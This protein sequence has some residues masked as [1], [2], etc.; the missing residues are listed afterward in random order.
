M[1]TKIM[2][3]KLKK[4]KVLKDFEKQFDG[5]SVL[6]L[7]D[8]GRGKS[9]LMQAIEIALGSKKSI[10]TEFN[11]SEGVVEVDK[12]GM[13]YTFSFK[14][15]KKGEL[16]LSVILPN[17]IKEDKKG[18]IAGIVGAIDFDINEFV[19][20]SD[21]TAGRKKQV[22]M[23]KK[24]LPA[25]I[26]A[27]LDAMNKKVQMSY[28]D[29]TELNRKI[30]TLKGFLNE[31]N[32][33]GKD[34]KVQPVDVSALTLELEKANA[35]NK[36]IEEVESR[37][38]E[39]ERSISSGQQRKKHIEEQ[40]AALMQEAE[41]VDKTIQE[42]SAKNVQATEWLKTNQKVDTS[43]ITAQIN[44]ANE[45]NILAAKAEEHNKK[46]AQLKE[47][48]EQVE[49]L[50]IM[51]DGSRQAIADAIRDMDSPVE[52]LS[53]NDEMLIYNGVPVEKSSLSTSEIIEL[54][55]KMKFASNPDYGVMMIE[56]GESL[57]QKRYEEILE[58]AKKYNL[59]LFIEQVVRGKEELE[60]QFIPELMN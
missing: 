55:I 46:L 34:L 20:L 14:S 53:F 5:N 25:E 17:G 57:G 22:E 56:H 36:K 23:F 50:T 42:D 52:G 21:S 1:A 16:K 31:D 6:L 60:V 9:S 29:R 59:Q 38:A 26:V 13:P 7:A 58:F 8:N 12:D 43:A 10:P 3:V 2:S 11:G 48:Q 19:E 44:S 49:N 41:Q 35:V 24:L 4:F 28:D 27:E 15:D 40:I 54:G 30:D 32:V 51:I 39:R 33:F 18:V 47:L 45:T 37:I